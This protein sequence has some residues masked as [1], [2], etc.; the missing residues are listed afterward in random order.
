MKDIPGWEGR[1]AVTE[2]GRIWNHKRKIF[3]KYHPDADGY[4]TFRPS[5]DGRYSYLKIHRI[6]A[7]A[8]VPNPENKPQVNHLDGDKT[9]NHASNLEWCTAKE[10]MHHAI[11]TGLIRQDGDQHVNAKLTR[12]E[13]LT[14][15][16]RLVEGCS[17]R[18]LAI[19][20]GVTI[21]T[22]SNIKTKRRYANVQ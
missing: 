8:F 19:Q 12:E 20:H 17:H 3:M 13:V 6:V 21:G 22:I 5:R 18:S 2:D 7:K 10:N 1:Y 4:L 9:N 15:R 11:R 16:N 14:I